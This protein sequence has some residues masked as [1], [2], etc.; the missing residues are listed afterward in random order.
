MDP[1][2]VQKLAD[3]RPYTGK[4]ALGLGLVDEIG[5]EQ[6]AL[7]WLQQKRHVV[8]GLPVQDDDGDRTFAHMLRSA[9][10]GFVVAGT[11]DILVSARDALRV[12][13]AYAVWQPSPS[14][15]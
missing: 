5:G 8:A 12:D 11:R 15:E 3:G 13:G 2:A 10:S 9:M 14:R 6:E 4:Q 7:S 1:A